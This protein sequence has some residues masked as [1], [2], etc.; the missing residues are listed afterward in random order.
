MRLFTS[1]SKRFILKSALLFVVL[2]VLYAI[3]VAVLKPKSSFVQ[4]QYQG[5]FIFAQEFIYLTRETF[6]CNCWLFHG[7]TYEV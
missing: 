5:N 3:A 6:Y 1:N 2:A 4:N 7:N